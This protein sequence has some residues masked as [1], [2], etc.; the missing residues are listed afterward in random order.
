ME[1]GDQILP[2]CACVPQQP[3]CLW[4]EF[5]VTQHIAQE[6]DPVMPLLFALGQHKSLIEALRSSTTSIA[7]MPDRVL[8]LEYTFI[9]NRFHPMTHDFI[10]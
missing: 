5:G 10:Q 6:G 1:G 8:E 3:T 4:D 9:Q 7:S 2:F